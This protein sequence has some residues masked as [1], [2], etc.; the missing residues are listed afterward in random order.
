MPKTMDEWICEY[1][2]YCRSRK[3][4]PKT[5]SNYEQTLYLFQFLTSQ[6]LS[7]VKSASVSYNGYRNLHRQ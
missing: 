3:L 1:M 5:M 6:A 2:Y 4:S 7:L